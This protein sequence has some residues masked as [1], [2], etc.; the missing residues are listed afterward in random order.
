MKRP[1]KEPEY[2]E[3]LVFLLTLEIQWQ[4]EAVALLATLWRGPSARGTLPRARLLRGHVDMHLEGMEMVGLA[5]AM[6]V[7]IQGQDPDKGCVVGGNSIYS[8]LPGD[9]SG[10]SGKKQRCATQ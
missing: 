3:E 7:W 10:G 8:H 2:R 1:G 5:V 9:L 6:P 4:L